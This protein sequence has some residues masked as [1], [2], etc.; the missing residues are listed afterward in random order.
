MPAFSRAIASIVSPRM[1]VCSSEIEVTAVEK[2]EALARVEVDPAV[3][4]TIEKAKEIAVAA[5]FPAEVVDKAVRLLELSGHTGRILRDPHTDR[6]PLPG[7]VAT[8]TEF[9]MIL[10]RTEYHCARYGGHQGH[11]FK[12]GPPP[13]GQ[14]YCNNGVALVFVPEG[15]P[16]PAVRDPG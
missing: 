6:E 13:T 15:E 14:R 8:K 3:G 1:A 9:K 11:V 7:A 10:P 16:L 4:I 5:K 12:D 2:P